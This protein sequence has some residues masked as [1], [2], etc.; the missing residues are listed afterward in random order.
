MEQKVAYKTVPKKVS[1]SGFRKSKNHFYK[2]LDSDLAVQVCGI[3]KAESVMM[4]PVRFAYSNP[5]SQDCSEAEY[6][7]A[8]EKVKK[9]LNL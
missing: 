9:I 5:K 1:I 7:E 4:V 2:I 8:F 6:Q 3:T